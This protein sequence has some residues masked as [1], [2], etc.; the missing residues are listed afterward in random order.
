MTVV[1]WALVIGL[2]SAAIALA[3]FVWNVWSK[4]IYPKPKVQMSFGYIRRPKANMPHWSD[5][6]TDNP[7]RADERNFFKVE[8]WTADDLHVA[9]ML[10]AGNSLDEAFEVLDVAIRVNPAGRYL[11]RQRSRVVDSWPKN[12]R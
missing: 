12:A 11:I 5:E 3:S 4:F 1:D 8:E 9:R 6:E 7:V 10:Y 2:F